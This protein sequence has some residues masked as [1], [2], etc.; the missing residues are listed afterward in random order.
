MFTI[1]LET[2]EARWEIIWGGGGRSKWKKTENN[3]AL[4][5]SKLRPW[6]ISFFVCLNFWDCDT[7]LRHRLDVFYGATKKASDLRASSQTAIRWVFLGSTPGQWVPKSPC[8]FW[9]PVPIRIP[10]QSHCLSNVPSGWCFWSWRHIRSSKMFDD[11]NIYPLPLIIH[12]LDHWT[13][14][15]VAI[16]I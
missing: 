15:D 4:V 1:K 3:Q 16:F 10:A 8:T 14:T 2:N 11:P 12:L 13:T 5:N 7:Y 6:D 9:L